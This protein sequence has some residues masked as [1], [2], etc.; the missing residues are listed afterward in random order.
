MDL[1]L[2]IKKETI[3][4]RI[5][6]LR[7]LEGSGYRCRALGSTRPDCSNIRILNMLEEL[8]K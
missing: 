4:T 2:A 8:V 3:D 7:H 1:S 6:I 5:P